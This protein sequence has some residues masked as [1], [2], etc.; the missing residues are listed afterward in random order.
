ML[1]ACVSLQEA[2]HKKGQSS[3]Y[4]YI[5]IPLPPLA[6]NETHKFSIVVAPKMAPD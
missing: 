5:S 1:S 4:D 2:A 3:G 6:M